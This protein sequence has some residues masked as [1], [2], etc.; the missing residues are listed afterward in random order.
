[1]INIRKA[2]KCGK[3]KIGDKEIKISKEVFNTK[4][5]WYSHC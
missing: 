4:E 3:A 2:K 1:M 5:E